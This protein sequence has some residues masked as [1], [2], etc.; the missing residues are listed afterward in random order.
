MGDFGHFEN[1]TT[2]KHSTKRLADFVVGRSNAR[3]KKYDFILTT[4]DNIYEDGLSQESNENKA[5]M[6]LK[7]T[8]KVEEL[9]TDWY[10]V[11]GNFISPFFLCFETCT[12]LLSIMIMYSFRFK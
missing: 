2:V 7:D 10:S 11:L 9:A 3:F 6:L 5:L 4:G 8:F 1:E 12:T